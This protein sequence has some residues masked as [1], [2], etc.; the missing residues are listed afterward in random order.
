M[1]S[2]KALQQKVGAGLHLVVDNIKVDRI[3]L[4]K[5]NR[6]LRGGVGFNDYKPFARVDMGKEAVRVTLR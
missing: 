3:T 1:I 5:G 6:M 2:I 4:P